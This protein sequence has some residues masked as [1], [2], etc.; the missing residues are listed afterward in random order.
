VV[1]VTGGAAARDLT[2]DLRRAGLAVDRAFEADS[3]SR[4]SMKSQMKTADRS[5]AT[6]VLI[7]G[8]DELAQ[9]Q[10]TLR[11]LREG[12]SQ[13]SIPRA[14]VTAEVRALLS[15]ELSPDLSPEARP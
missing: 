3:T 6:L 10:V 14:D 4:R 11:T 12:G 15:P 9:G 1:D 13:R 8:E 5:G 7:V 2:L